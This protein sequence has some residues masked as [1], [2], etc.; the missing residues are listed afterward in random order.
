MAK[1]VDPAKL[2]NAWKAARPAL[3]YARPEH[4]RKFAAH[5]VPH[6]V[7]PAQ[8]IW[9]QAI[10]A[11]FMLFSLSFFGYA[12][13]HLS[14]AAAMFGGVFLG[15]VMGFFGVDFFSE[16]SPPVSSLASLRSL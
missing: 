2:A 6:V 4:A 1:L 7:R 16:S 11:I 3:K 13:T 9:N 12:G 15:L 10:G 14:N 5:M 8:I